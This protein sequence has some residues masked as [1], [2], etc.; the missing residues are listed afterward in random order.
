VIFARWSALRCV[1]AALL[2]G[3]AGAIGPALQSIGVSQGY[4]LFAAVPYVLT[5]VILVISCRPGSVA[6]GSPGELSSVRSDDRK[7][8][9]IEMS[10]LGGLNKSPNGVVI[11]LVQLQLP[12]VETPAQLA[13][14]ADRI[15]AMV[16]KARRNNA[17]LDLVVFP[18][19]ALHGLSM[20]TAPELMCRMDG[21][22][23]PRSRPRASSTGSGAASR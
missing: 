20:T 9:G 23:S 21:P 1:G 22:R 12:V 16:G 7:P 17:G 19:Y 2:F 5:L 13:A 10:G 8:H 4:Y 18:E 14:Q 6:R 3:G 15:V 11:G